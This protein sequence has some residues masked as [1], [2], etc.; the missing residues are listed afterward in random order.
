[1]TMKEAAKRL[2][3]GRPALSNFLNGRSSQ[4]PIKIDFPGCDSAYRK[5]S[6]Y[7]RKIG[8]ERSQ[9]RDKIVTWGQKGREE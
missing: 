4:S 6:P 7:K 8:A 1:M 5:G 3:I 2:G 9:R